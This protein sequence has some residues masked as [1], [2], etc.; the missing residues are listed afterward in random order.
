MAGITRSAAL[1]YAKD[2]IRVVGIAPTG[3]RTAL[4]DEFIKVNHGLVNPE[5]VEALVN[6]LNPMPSA[7]KPE[8]FGSAVAFLA[9]DQAKFISG[10]ILPLDSACLTGNQNPVWS[11]D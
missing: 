10:T 7:P 8:D 1:E 11:T 3:I 2:G 6:S 5:E 9:S 4:I